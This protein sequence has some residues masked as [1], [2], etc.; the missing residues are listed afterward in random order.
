MRLA[1]TS[2]TVFILLFCVG[3]RCGAQAATPAPKKV[4]VIL[5]TDI[6]RYMDDAFALALILAS[7]ELE[8]RGV[9]TVD[10][11]A[12]TRA[13]LACNFLY[14]VNR[15]KV[16][17]AAGSP[18]RAKPD[19]TGQMQYGLRPAYTRPV[20]QLAVEFL[21][22]QLK[23]APGELTILCI[24]PLTNIAALLEKHP[25]AAKWIKRLVIM[26]GSLTVGYEGK[27]GAVA[28]WNVRQDIKAAKKVFSSDVPILLVPLDAASTLVADEGL[29]KRIFSAP[30]V[31][32][33]HLH[34][35]Y[36]LG[37]K[38][39]L[40]LFDPLAVAITFRESFCTFADMRIEVDDRGLTRQVEGK[41][42]AR[43]ALS[44][45]KAALLAA[46]QRRLVEPVI[47]SGDLG[48][49]CTIHVSAAG[50]CSVLGNQ[51]SL[52]QLERLL[53]QAA[54]AKPPLKMVT[55]RANP[56][57]AYRHVVALMERVSAAGVTRYAL[58]ASK[59]VP[60]SLPI[61]RG[62]LPN[63]VHVAENYE[64]DIEHRWW[65]AGKLETK[66]LPE[67]SRR[68]CRAVLCRDFD[69][70]QGDRW[71]SYKA[72]IFNPVPGPPMGK[73]TR[74][75]FRYHLQGTDTIR[76]QLYTLSKGYH[77]QLTIP[78]LPQGR[79]ETA[80]VDMTQA[81]RPD[82]SGGPLEENERIDDIQFYVD[83]AAE[84]LIDDIVLYDAAADDEKKPFPKQVHFTGWFDTG[85]Q[86]AEWPGDFRIVEHK[87]PRTWKAAQSVPAPDGKTPWIRID[88]RGPR[89]ITPQTRL[90]FWYHAKNTGTIV[91]E[92]RLRG[93]KKHPAVSRLV[94]K[95]DAEGEFDVDF[96]DAFAATA[97]S[98]GKL[99]ASYEATDIVFRVVAGGELLV[100]DVLLYEPGETEKKP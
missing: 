57:T 14:A 84:L 60:K 13:Q 18:P 76:V 99:L 39:P 74:L 100:D 23:A 86:G 43:V 42:T 52:Q 25:E 68:A 89:P 98:G 37:G 75:T 95:R 55:I 93:E 92:L 16:P 45:E 44:V 34:A 12:F 80:T 27:P 87:P 4:P 73:N 9:T 64:T 48:E 70:Q 35:L 29:C 6:G 15:S 59:S 19:Y 28:E 82:R 94:G 67:G 88:L 61:A 3:Q 53:K 22:D 30:T 79:W 36:E 41:P 78:D 21:H 8:L 38:D 40:V 65:L 90:R 49:T 24:G 33:N 2:C 50:D 72:V 71:A 66:H 91:A 5:D 32:A 11:D 51:L 97:P 69:D 81:R 17:V 58:E 47:T 31:L 54:A 96:T 10:G 62:M 77:R 85:K 46:V 63:R 20:K 83:A 26:G 56:A 7:P 1:C